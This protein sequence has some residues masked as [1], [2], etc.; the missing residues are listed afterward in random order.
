M[1]VENVAMCRWHRWNA[2][3]TRNVCNSLCNT[4][5]WWN[6]TRSLYT[7]NKCFSSFY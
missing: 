3:F 1:P 7:S 6:G 2:L 4:R 5:K